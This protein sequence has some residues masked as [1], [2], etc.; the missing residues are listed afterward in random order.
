MNDSNQDQDKILSVQVVD[1][2]AP[3]EADLLQPVPSQRH[4]QRSLRLP[5]VLF[6]A[7]CFSTFYVGTLP[8]MSL[9]WEAA[10]ARGLKYSGVLMTILICHE[11]GHFLQSYRYGVFATWPFFI[12]IPCG[13]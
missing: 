13:R 11:M 5:V 8:A 3:D 10:V 4:R 6:I 1:I 7:T 9:G 2:M 12:P